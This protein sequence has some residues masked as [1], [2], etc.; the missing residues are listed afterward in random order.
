MIKQLMQ[1][2]KN[3]NKF[4]YF[5]L[6]F[7][8]TMVAS[9]SIYLGDTWLGI[10]SAIVNILC[11]ILVAQGKISNYVFGTV[12][13]L[14][15]GYI[16][17]INRI[18][19]DFMLNILYYLPMQFYGYIQWKKADTSNTVGVKSMTNKE[20]VL[21]T[22]MSAVAIVIYGFILKK[23]NGQVPFLD[24]TSTVLS[25]VSMYLMSK[26][27]KEQWCGWILVNCV[28]I[29]MW[30]LADTT[31]IS[32]LLMWII[33]LANSLIGLYKWFRRGN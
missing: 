22:L 10:M 24:S 32:A 13:V 29:T 6:I 28:S 8:T 30:A 23:L 25:I 2:F 20:R 31:Q 16:A 9:I 7:A 33:F 26:G 5:W 3:W 17:F 1:D 4:D 18:Y 21:T 19:G 14:T 15:Y 12:G 11:V 27:Y